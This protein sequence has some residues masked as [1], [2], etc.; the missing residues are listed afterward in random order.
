VAPGRRAVTP[1]PYC[2][3]VAEVLLF[4]HAQ[5]LTGGV[6]AFADQLRATGHVV[7]AP[8][9]YEGATFATVDEGV[10]HARQTGFDTILARGRAAADALGADLVYAGFSLGVMSAQELTQTRPGARGGLFFHGCLPPGEFDAPWP[11]GVRAQ[12]HAMADD[13]WM[14]E[15]WESARALVA[16]VPGAELFI[17][18]GAG[19]LFAEVG[20]ADYD[21]AAAT[22]LTART[23]EFLARLG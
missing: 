18:P 4:H 7:H 20:G 21:E 12:V 16:T 14:E 8:D 13:P 10:A 11:L 5:G 3:P 19:H 23:L 15:D 17:Y 6:V 2:G 1:V 9:L 22:L